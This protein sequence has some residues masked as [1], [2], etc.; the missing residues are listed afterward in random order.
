[1]TKE[2][3]AIETAIRV[4]LFSG[5]KID[6]NHWEEKFM[7]KAKRKGLKEICNGTKMI[8][9]Y[10][11]EDDEDYEEMTEEEIKEYKKMCELN[12]LAYSDLI[13]SMDTSTTAGKVAYDL[14]KS[15]KSKDFPDG[16]AAIS[17]KR[18]KHKY[19]PET[20]MSLT[21]LAART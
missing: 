11:D 5:K 21:L 17:W 6:W 10:I 18:L 1:M 13:M 2:S 19:L 9:N 3:S 12:E 7:A 15:S 20:S 8:P 16:N 4:L 14:V